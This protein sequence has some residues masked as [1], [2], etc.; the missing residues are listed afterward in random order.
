MKTSVARFEVEG[1]TTRC[2]SG[3][4]VFQEHLCQGR[5]VSGMRSVAGRPCYQGGGDPM[6]EGWISHLVGQYAIESFA[7]E[8]D[9]QSLHGHWKMAGAAGRSGDSA[10]GTVTL[11]HGHVP[12]RVAVQSVLDGQGFVE[13][14]LDI[15]NLSDEP[16]A[17]SAVEPLRGLLWRLNDRQEH[18]PRDH[19]TLA[20]LP[21]V[22]WGYE[23]TMDWRPL[24]PGITAL[25]SYFGRSGWGVPWFLAKNNINGE[26]VVGHLEWSANWAM[27][28][29]AVEMPGQNESL[30]LFGIG[31]KARAPMR[32]V[33]P[34]QTIASPRVHLG[35]F[36]GGWTRP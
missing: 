29:E 3:L 36:T 23:G 9:G 33:E 5:W 24:P 22:P 12:V 28:F 8:M 30:L 15:T 14:W 27:A 13:R 6:G 2:V 26:I 25:G 4:A 16:M 10:G 34:G 31:P 11:E 17:L 7:L 32:V 35:H 1:A 19:W 18:Q 20:T 21:C